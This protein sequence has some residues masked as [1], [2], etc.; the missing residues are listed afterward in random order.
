MDLFEADPILEWSLE[1]EAHRNASAMIDDICR[2]AKQGGGEIPLEPFLRILKYESAEIRRITS[3]REAI[4][5]QSPSGPRGKLEGAFVNRGD[6]L[7]ASIPRMELMSAVMKMERIVKGRF[8]AQPGKVT[9]TNIQG[10][11]ILKELIEQENDEAMTLSYKV[12]RL[13]L[14]PESMAV[15]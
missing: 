10:M 5:I 3:Q 2:V 15:F 6:A 14:K 7:E 12:K 13:V 8:H 9:L 4:H 11:T 1:G